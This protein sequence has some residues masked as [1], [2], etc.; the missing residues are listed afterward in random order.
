MTV[1]T[2]VANCLLV[3][4]LMLCSNTLQAQSDSSKSNEKDAY[5]GIHAN[6]LVRQL[7]PSSASS[8]NNNFNYLL[9]Y[10]KYK[11]GYK[12]GTRMS[13]NFIL[14]SLSENVNNTTRITN[15]NIFQYKVGKEKLKVLEKGFS[16]ALGWD[17][18]LSLNNSITRSSSLISSSNLSTS[19]TSN[20]LAAGTGPGIRIT[21]NLS[22]RILLGTDAGAYFSTIVNTTTVVERGNNQP[23]EKRTSDNKVDF[24]IG[25]QPPISL[26]LLV[27]VK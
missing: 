23:F 19:I 15:N 4:V 11:P 6:E 22:P 21:Y 2:K 8:V 3:V 13:G 14:N 10:I 27:K 25:I 1:F 16:Y 20:I 7:I 12:Y 26:Y 24:S 18:L 17:V 5:L 9:S